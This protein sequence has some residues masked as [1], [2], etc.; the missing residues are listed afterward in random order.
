MIL[1][2]NIINL[3]FFINL[4]F[5]LFLFSNLKANEVKILFKINEKIGTNIDIENEFN[6]LTSLNPQLKSIDETQILE[7]AKSSLIKEIVKKFEISKYYELNKKNE[8]VDIMIEKIYRN[9]GINSKEKFKKYLNENNLDFNEVY[10]KIEIEA[11]WNQMIYDRFKD[12]IS[13]DENQI[14]ETILK[15]PKKIEELLLSEILIEFKNKNEVQN[16]YNQIIKSIDDI[17]FE[18]TVIKFSI[19]NSKNKSGSLGWINKNSLSKNIIEELNDIDVGEI[20]KPILVSSGMMILKLNDKK[21]VQQDINIDQE[22]NKM[23]DFEMNKQLNN[24]STIHY[25]KIKS[26]LIINEY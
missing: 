2:K 19:S 9:L 15:N 25:N 14:K 11:V 21:L 26:N 4:I 17:G 18:E 1:K 13:I 12:K 24:L 23:I 5:F 6:Y 10:Q 3:M 16:I 8:S 22:I 7:F 20:T